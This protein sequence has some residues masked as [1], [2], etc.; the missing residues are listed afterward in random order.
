MVDQ[1]RVFISYARQDG[2]A[3]AT[4][5]RRRLEQEQPEITLWHDRAQLEGGIGWWRQIAEALDSVDFLILILTPAAVHS[6]VVR[7]EWRYARQRGVCVYPV[8]GVTDTELD[9]RSL[10]KWMGKAHIFDLDREWDTFVNYLKSP[11]H[12]ARVPFMAPDL[13]ESYVE[14]SELTERVLALLI[15]K[16]HEHFIAINITLFGA[17][18]LGK[19]TLAAALCHEEDI[20][21]SFDDGILWVTLGQNPNIQDSLTKLYA[22]LSGLRPGFV[23]KDD[24]AFH[25]SEKLEDKNCLIVIDDVWDPADLEPF[26]QGGRSCS[27]LIT[28]RNF[29]ISARTSWIEIDQMSVSEAVQMLTS[30]FSGMPIELEPFKELAKRLGYWPLLLELTNAALRQRI[31]RGDTTE[32]ALRYLNR[33]LDERGVA[34]FDQRNATARN[35]ALTRTLEISLNQLQKEELQRFTSL[36]IF[37]G[38]IGVPV[39][40]A[41]SLWGCD[42]FEAEDLIQRL[43]SLSLV[44]LSLDTGRFRLHDVMRG[45]IRKSLSDPVGLN[46]KFIDAWGDLKQLNTDYA[47]RWAPFHLIESGNEERLRALLL[48]F[49]WIQAK[50]AA[51]DIIS[52]IHDFHFFPEDSTLQLMLGSLRLSAHVLIRDKTQIAGQMLGRLNPHAS[53]EL[54][55]F[56]K[57]A[58][59]WMGAPWLRPLEPC[60]IE[61]GGPLL[62]T[63]TGHSGAVRSVAL[64]SDGRYAVS[65]SDDLTIR[66]WDLDRGIEKHVL[67]GH[68]DWV[69]AIVI[70]PDNYRVISAGDDQTIR[71]W[72]METGKLLNV[73]EVAG[74]WP[75]ALAVTPDGR[76][77]LV[78]GRG[79]T[80]K[81]VDLLKGKSELSLKGH[82][83]T[84]NS[85]SIFSDGNYAVS[86]SDDRTLR[87]WSLIDGVGLFTLRGHRAKV[88]ASA[89]SSDGSFALSASSDD[90]LRFWPLAE[91]KDSDPQNGVVITDIAYWVR[92]VDLTPDG[93]KAITGA[94]D[95]SL[96]AWNMETGTLLRIFEGH[97]DRINAVAVT[98]DGKRAVSASNDRTLRVW[99]LTSGGLHR[100]RKGHTKRLRALVS[101]EDGSM[102]VSTSDDHKLKVWQTATRQE[103]RS[104]AGYGRWP[105]AVSPDGRHIVSVSPRRFASLQVMNCETWSV[106]QVLKGHIDVL[107]AV[108]IMPDSRQVVSASDDCTIR[109]WDISSGNPLLSIQTQRDYVR[110]LAAIPDGRCVI[111][112]SYNGIIKLWDLETGCEVRRFTGHTE[113]INALAVSPDGKVFLSTSRDNTLR[114]WNLA[115]GVEEIAV[116]AHEGEINGV[117]I[118]RNNKYAVSFSDDCTVKLWRLLDLKLKAT[119]TG[120]SPMKVCAMGEQKVI[121]AGDQSGC[122]H[123]L[124]IEEV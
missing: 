60:L 52:L 69:R 41:A 71:I 39:E 4:T 114:L 23:D 54:D 124:N 88:V 112:G 59:K 31:E 80:I 27:R 55:S 111:S 24:V 62:V 99:D 86:A 17:G 50:L 74:L 33:V 63:L 21:G 79:R 37:P 66:I 122:L 46:K 93:Q 96:R 106:H 76:H 92:T 10:P 40:Q 75:Q 29:E 101:T 35:Y 49:E 5:L 19:S 104:F 25:L 117:L 65:A 38:N 2:E 20:V 64:T 3:F 68:S 91:R 57:Q 82:R 116:E 58:S 13:P 70:S 22:A 9:Y 15:D 113:R 1:P 30:R 89:V 83:S 6:P 53:T 44:K 56:C 12:A 100:S 120:D 72:E 28:T 110:T 18:G 121:M 36:A 11:C 90:T 81:F 47:W 48:D 98:R 34:A 108:V 73:I 32:N 84:I 78:G 26:L 43:D 118:D 8:K 103:I 105:L 14:R 119:Y 107:R 16:S 95:G 85:I 77:V 102:A 45:V 51:T 109:S 97:V 94:D 42:N 67:R 123:F 61:P 115:S 87:I 7:Q